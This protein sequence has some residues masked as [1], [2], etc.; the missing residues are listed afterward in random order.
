MH[1]SIALA[2]SA[3]LSPAAGD[4]GSTTFADWEMNDPPSSSTVSDSGPNHLDGAIK[5]GANPDGDTLT[6]DGKSGSVTVKGATK[7]P[8]GSKPVTVS[9]RLKFANVPGTD[10]GDYDIVR[11]T[12]GGTF[13]LEV[14]ARKN[15]TIA[16]ALCFFNGSSAKANLVAGPDL[17]DN[18]WHTVVCKKTDNAVTLTVDGN[19]VGTKSVKIGTVTLTKE[20]LY[21]G[22]KPGGDWYKGQ[23]DWARI[24]LG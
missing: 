9:A 12:P 15:R 16:Q 2:L 10:V 13:R 14:V 11:A 19:Q 21:I 18:E 5:G 23:L 17:A 4:A 6:F 3:A 22:S 1:A 24:D 7:V 8:I 20:P